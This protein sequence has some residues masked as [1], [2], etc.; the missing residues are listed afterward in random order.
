V[1]FNFLDTGTLKLY[2][3]WEG[4]IFFN[5]ERYLCSFSFFSLEMTPGFG[6]LGIV[7]RDEFSE[8]FILGLNITITDVL[9][10]CL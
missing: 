1:N 9:F 5:W 3:E 2:V 8:V 6:I 10:I 4:R 7:S